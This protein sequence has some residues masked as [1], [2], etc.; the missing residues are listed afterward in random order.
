MTD[1][2]G[3]ELHVNDT[4]VF[5]ANATNNPILLEG[6]ITRISEKNECSVRGSDGQ[7]R[8]HV[9]TRR[10]LHTESIQK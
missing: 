10:I 5:I 1:R 4:V 6:V 7:I 8:S 9:Y 2:K 3:R